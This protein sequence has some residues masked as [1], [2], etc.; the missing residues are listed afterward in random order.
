MAGAPLLLN[1][2]R[3]SAVRM[4]SQKAKDKSKKKDKTK[5]KKSSVKKKQRR[6]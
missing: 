6:G 5:K 3:N 2:W 4:K 1:L